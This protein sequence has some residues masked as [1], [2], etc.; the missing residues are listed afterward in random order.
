MGLGIDGLVILVLGKR[1]QKARHE[2]Q[3]PWNIQGHPVSIY[4]YV[5]LV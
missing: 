1:R 5:D 4:V 2:G 3:G